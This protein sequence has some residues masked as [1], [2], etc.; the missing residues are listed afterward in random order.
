MSGS[1]PNQPTAD[2][3]TDAATLRA[4]ATARL[5]LVIANAAVYYQI[6][7]GSILRFSE[8]EVFAPPG[9]YTLE[10]ACDGIRVRSAKPGAPALVSVAAA[11]AR[12][13]GDV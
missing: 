5:T 1:L 11:T 7:R 13:A 2:G 9:L 12:E 8:P 6:G 10:R 4:P 3:Y